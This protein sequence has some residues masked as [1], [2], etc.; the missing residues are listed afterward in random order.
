M[1]GFPNQPLYFL[2]ISLERFGRYLAEGF[3]AHLIS[4]FYVSRGPV[5]QR[6]SPY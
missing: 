4:Q 6:C 5:R 2:R 1:V 3:L